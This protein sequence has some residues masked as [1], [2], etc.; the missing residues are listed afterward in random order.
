MGTRLLEKLLGASSR[1]WRK[2]PPVCELQTRS[3][4]EIHDRLQTFQDPY[5]DCEYLVCHL[6]L[7]CLV[8]AV[9]IVASGMRCSACSMHA[10]GSCR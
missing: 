9:L 1:D 4:E 7:H 8:L 10:T 3:D 6:A 2:R 5:V